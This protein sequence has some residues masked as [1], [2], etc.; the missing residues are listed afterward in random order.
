MALRHKANEIVTNNRDKIISEEDNQKSDELL[1]GNGF[2]Y[3]W[4]IR[5][6]YYCLAL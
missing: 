3:N 6:F 2:L 5:H 1:T 4:S